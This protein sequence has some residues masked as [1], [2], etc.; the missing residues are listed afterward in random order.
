[1]G[2]R[3]IAVDANGNSYLIGYTYD[4]GGTANAYLRKYDSDGNHLWSKQWSV[5]PPDHDDYAKAVAVGGGHVVV[6]GNTLD[7]L[8]GAQ[9]AFV[10]VLAALPQ[11]RPSLPV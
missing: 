6:V 1:M 4:T 5:S 10:R 2:S 11:T 3:A 8:F 9:Y 7:L